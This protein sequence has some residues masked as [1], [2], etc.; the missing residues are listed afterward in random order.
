MLSVYVGLKWLK[1]SWCWAVCTY[2]FIF[3][4]R[5]NTRYDYG[6]F[7]RPWCSCGNLICQKENLAFFL[8]FPMNKRFLLLKKV[9]PSL[10]FNFLFR[11]L[12]YWKTHL[13][14]RILAQ[15]KYCN[16]YVYCYHHYIN[17]DPS[18]I[19]CKKIDTVLNPPKQR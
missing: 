3:L 7:E 4:S 14:C 16:R 2:F 15:N 9:F 10:F 13:N 11:S 18:E 1:W 12:K 19:W 8:R 5:R 6:C 17:Y